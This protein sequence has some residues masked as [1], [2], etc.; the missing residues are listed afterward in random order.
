MY[1]EKYWEVII[2]DFEETAVCFS[3]GD[4][5]I[6]VFFPLKDYV[7]KGVFVKMSNIKMFYILCCLSRCVL[8]ELIKKEKCRKIFSYYNKVFIFDKVL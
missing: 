4:C 1:S 8:N 2:V 6:K 5:G 7:V 3:G